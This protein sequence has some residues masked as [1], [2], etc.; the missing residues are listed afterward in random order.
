MK[1][2][3]LKWRVSLLVAG[4]TTVIV[5]ATCALAYAETKELLF[6]QIDI[7]LA[8]TART[9]GAVLDEAELSPTQIAQLEALVGTSRR[10]Q[11]GV[12]RIWVVGAQ[13]DV[14]AG[15]LANRQSAL[16]K[17]L[18]KMLQPTRPDKPFPFSVGGEEA[19]RAVWVLMPTRFGQTNIVVA[20]TIQSVQAE[21][22]QLLA[23]LIIVG[24][25]AIAVSIVLSAGLVWLGLKPIKTT[26]GRLVGISA[27]NVGKVDL[28]D[29]PAPAELQPFV[30]AVSDML[31]RLD[32]AMVRQKAFVSD[33]SHELRTPVALAKSTAQLALSRDR[34]DDEYRKSLQDILADMRRMEHLTDELLTLAR[35]D[36]N[37]GLSE[38]T[39][40]DLSIL[41]RDLAERFGQQADQAGGKI[42]SSL[43][44]AIVHGNEALLTMLFS[45][46]IDNALK[47]GLKGGQVNIT[48]TQAGDKPSVVIVTVRDEGGGISP[49][50]L[51]HL[52]DRFFRADPSRSQA[53]GG[54][55]LGLAI[56]REI[57]LRHNG[58]IEIK[59]SR[60]D[61]TIVTVQLPSCQG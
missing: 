9:A 49:E 60:P 18:A 13:T 11:W 10:R 7:D 43:S 32:G 58:T 24:G 37:A 46:L 59:S 20:Q 31:N 30:Q 3:P 55:G 33:A 34:S 57:V 45:N 21:L 22:G 40:V 51:P 25:S 28:A 36:E 4:A 61:G 48:L 1:P 19:Y 35:M 38:Q 54:A 6:R 26:A 16:A 17:A 52:F 27:Q 44:P 56:A 2:L 23:T 8:A 15:G 5:I 53:T 14:I 50:A 12:Y 39:S 47:H 42:A 29:P 41:L